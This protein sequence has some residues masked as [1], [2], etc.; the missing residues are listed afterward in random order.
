MGPGDVLFQDDVIN[1]PAR[2]TPVHYTS[3]A[4]LLLLVTNVASKS[5]HCY[6]L[7]YQ[8]IRML[9]SAVWKKHSCDASISIHNTQCPLQLILR[10]YPRRA[11]TAQSSE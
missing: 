10:T 7:D 1:S 2:K 11:L 5:L 8:T 3:K 4:C 6:G 9:L